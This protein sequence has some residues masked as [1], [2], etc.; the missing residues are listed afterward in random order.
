M[1]EVTAYRKHPTPRGRASLPCP[2]SP[3]FLLSCRGVQRVLKLC[4]QS[5]QLL[6]QVPLLLFRLVPRS[7]LGFKVFLQLSKLG[8][9]LSHDFKRVV[10]V[11]CLVVTPAETPGHGKRSEPAPG[12]SSHKETL[13]HHPQPTAHG[14]EAQSWYQ[15]GVWVLSK[16]LIKFSVKR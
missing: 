1:L 9:Q 11:Q 2:H 7:L 4:L 3:Q 10:L 16:G 12:D 5:F 13:R 15:D 6:T 8:L 14:L